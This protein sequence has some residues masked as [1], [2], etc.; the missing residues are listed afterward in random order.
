MSE[1]VL[2]PLVTLVIY[3]IVGMGVGAI[4]DEEANYTGSDHAHYAVGALWLPLLIVMIPV[5]TYRLF[6]NV[7][8]GIKELY[9][10]YTR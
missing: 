9:R 4:W 7:M 2:G 10:Y 3:G 5:W 6:R 1:W 8:A